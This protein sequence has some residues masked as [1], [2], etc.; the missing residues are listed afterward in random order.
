MIT[1]RCSTGIIAM[2]K[3]KELVRHFVVATILYIQYCPVFGS[4][5][6]SQYENITFGSN[7]RMKS[8]CL[9]DSIIGSRPLSPS[10][11]SMKC[12]HTLIFRVW[13]ERVEFF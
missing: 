7:W 5:R 13:L 4:L 8:F 10:P 9:R 2:W 11:R 12:I 6:Y 3:I 1:R